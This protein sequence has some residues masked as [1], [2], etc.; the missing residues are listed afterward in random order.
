M[1]VDVKRVAPLGLHPRCHYFT[2]VSFFTRI[3]HFLRVPRFPLNY[4]KISKT[5][6]QAKGFLGARSAAWVGGL[7]GGGGACSGGGWAGRGGREGAGWVNVR[8]DR[9]WQ[10]YKNRIQTVYVS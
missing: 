5:V 1:H 6:V 9:G 10:S 2:L 3:E 8:L 4:T 7:G